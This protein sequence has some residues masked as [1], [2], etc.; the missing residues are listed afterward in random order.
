LSDGVEVLDGGQL[1]HA[2]Q[3]TGLGS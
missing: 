3:G 1:G 2:D